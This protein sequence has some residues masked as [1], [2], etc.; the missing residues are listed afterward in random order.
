MRI[1]PNVNRYRNDERTS[2]RSSFA[3]IAA[4]YFLSI[5][6]VHHKGIYKAQSTLALRNWDF[7]PL[8]EF[9]SRSFFFPVNAHR[10]L[11]ITHRSIKTVFKR[12]IHRE[13]TRLFAFR[14]CFIVPDTFVSQVTPRYRYIYSLVQDWNNGPRVS[15]HAPPFLCRGEAMAALQIRAFWWR[16][17]ISRGIS[18][19][20]AR[21]K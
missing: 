7:V 20:Y 1:Q 6:Q 18:N 14:F 19:I 15:M 12:R 4:N 2:T 11:R 5:A 16:E 13:D 8:F 21:L 17:I 9:S 3:E 10:Q